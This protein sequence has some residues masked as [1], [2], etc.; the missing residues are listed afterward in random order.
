M[1]KK[2]SNLN[3][4]HIGAERGS[5]SVS[6]ILV[7]LVFWPSDIITGEQL[8][9]TVPAPK[10]LHRLSRM[11]AF[12]IVSLLCACTSRWWSGYA[13]IR[14]ATRS[15][16]LSTSVR[17]IAFFFPSTR[18]HNASAG[19][20]GYKWKRKIPTVELTCW[21]GRGRPTPLTQ[22]AN[23]KAWKAKRRLGRYFPSRCCC[24]LHMRATHLTTYREEKPPVLRSR[25]LFQK[26][27]WYSY[28]AELIR[29]G[30][31]IM[32]SCEHSRTWKCKKEKIERKSSSCTWHDH[33]FSINTSPWKHW[34]G[35]SASMSRSGFLHYMSTWICDHGL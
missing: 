24:S 22:V 20:K 8:K 4:D 3:S 18:R 1:K 26:F 35:Q 12:R 7:I 10:V 33:N 11:Y 16:R 5:R 27:L 34:R 19:S 30:C 13:K 31:L 29:H 23:S 2:K 32:R 17:E 21:V 6:K 28:T 15:Q 9:E 25:N 14:E